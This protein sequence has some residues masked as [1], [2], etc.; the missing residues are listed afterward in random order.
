MPHAPPRV[1]RLIRGTFTSAEP[2]EGWRHFHVVEVRKGAEGWEAELAASCDDARRVWVLA[3][4]L[5]RKEGWTPGWT[6]LRDL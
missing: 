4:K 1:S 3:A 2:V 6:P 5:L